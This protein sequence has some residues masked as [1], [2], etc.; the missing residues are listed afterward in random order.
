MQFLCLNSNFNKEF[1]L[2]FYSLKSEFD[3]KTADYGMP[4]ELFLNFFSVIKNLS[5]NSPHWK[6]SS[7]IYWFLI[8]ILAWQVIFWRYP[9]YILLTWSLKFSFKVKD[10]NKPLSRITIF[11][12][13]NCWKLCHLVMESHSDLG[14]DPI[15][16]LIPDILPD[17]WWQIIDILA[18]HLANSK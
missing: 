5:L 1:K 16:H 4:W 14:F 13:F 2:T 17:N 10:W 15:S 9:Q 18:S 3:Q 11:M 12:R 6:S 7:I 8:A